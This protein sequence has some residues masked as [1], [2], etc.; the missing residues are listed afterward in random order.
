[1]NLS[2]LNLDILWIGWHVSCN[3][4]LEKLK[5]DMKVKVVESNTDL[6]N[7][8]KGAE[9]TYLLLYKKGSELSECAYTGLNS[10]DDKYNR[11]NLLTADVN[12]VRDI[13][14]LYGIQ[15]VPSL[16]VFEG[17]EF[18]TVIKGCQSMQYYESLF[19]SSLYHAEPMSDKP[20]KNVTVYST[21]SCSW[22]TTLKNYLRKQG[23]YFTDV[24]ISADPALA[25]DLV[26]RS[27]QQ[28]VPQTEIDGQIIIGFDKTKINRLLGLNG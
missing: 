23:V 19:D 4:C 12:L 22:C 1:M 6:Q 17:L 3:V 16:L 5:A 15:S 9:R 27:G 18:K 14:G 13:H 28:G 20:R 26:R 2:A 11:I 24:D 8:L 21:P 25:E 7:Q 10:L